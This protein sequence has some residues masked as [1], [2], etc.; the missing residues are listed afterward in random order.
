MIL[1]RANTPGVIVRSISCGFIRYGIEPRTLDEA[2]MPPQ[3]E[4]ARPITAASVTAT[5]KHTP[6]LLERP[7]TSGLVPKTALHDPKEVTP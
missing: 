7:M 6:A 1:S 4:A 5:P 3:H 2:G